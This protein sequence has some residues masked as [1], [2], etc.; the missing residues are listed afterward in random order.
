MTDQWS[1]IPA[2]HRQPLSVDFIDNELPRHNKVFKHDHAQYDPV[3]KRYVL[4]PPTPAMAPGQAA[5]YNAQNAGSSPLNS[6]TPS[7]SSMKFWNEIFDPAKKKLCEQSEP[8]TVLKSSCSIRT[9]STWE[10]IY[11]QLQ[12]ARE[13]YDGTK[14]G[15]W[16]SCLRAVRKIG[17]NTE[18]A[19]QAIK[20]IPDVDYVSPVLA[21]LEVVLDVS[22]PGA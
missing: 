3:V 12:K 2:L 9:E 17:D 21:A 15:F 7:Q 18:I 16:G 6:P 4:I 20:Y 1:R 8:K 22:F 19:T 5:G 13:E 14:K 11:S 10:G